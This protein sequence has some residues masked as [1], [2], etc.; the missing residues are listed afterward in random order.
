[1]L[2]IGEIVVHN[3]FAHKFYVSQEWITC[4]RAYAESKGRLCERCL[5]R[6]IINPGTKEHPLQTHHKIK[7][8]PENVTDPSVSLN[9]DNLELLCF[10]CHQKDEHYHCGKRRW[11]FDR[12]GKLRILDQ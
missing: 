6:G 9:W 11:R 3:G 7:L 8:T 1:M 4:R 10:E 2:R 12:D 5:A